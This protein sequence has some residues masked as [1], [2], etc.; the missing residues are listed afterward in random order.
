MPPWQPRP[1]TRKVPFDP[2]VDLDGLWTPELA[3][4]Y[5]P[6]PG[7]PPAKYE[8][9]DGKLLMGPRGGTANMFAV[10]QLGKRLETAAEQEGHHFYLTVDVLLD[11]P[12]V[13]RARFR[14]ARA[15][16]AR[17]HL[18]PAERGAVEIELLGLEDGKYRTHASST[19]AEP[20][21]TDLPFPLSFDPSELLE[22]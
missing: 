6:I 19:Q 4:R 13:D 15:A 12:E 14:G 2:L 16:R 11:G 7:M 9:L 22:R 20:F 3:D 21:E 10:W 5:L 1:P 8:C 17:T 18:D